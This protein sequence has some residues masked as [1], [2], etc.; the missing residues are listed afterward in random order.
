M[1]EGAIDVP[2]PGA[3]IPAGVLTVEGW[4]AYGRKPV[5][6]VFVQAGDQGVLRASEQVRIDVAEHFASPAMTECGFRAEFDLRHLM[7]QPDER[8]SI[9]VAVIVDKDDIGDLP[10]PVVK[11]LGSV[12]VVVDGSL[13]SPETAISQEPLPNAAA[14]LNEALAHAELGLPVPKGARFRGLKR[15]VARLN[16]PFLHRQLAFNNAVVAELTLQLSRALEDRV[17]VYSQLENMASAFERIVGDLR[18]ELDQ[19]LI[20]HRHQLDLVQRQAFQRHYE[21]L[22]GLRSELTEMAL[23]LEGVRKQ[24]DRGDSLVSRRDG[25]FSESAESLNSTYAAFE[26]T[27]RGSFD[28][29]KD[30][31]RD[32]LG[33]VL[34]LDRHG[35]VLDVGCGR[36]EWLEVLKEA[37]VEAYGVD[38]DVEFVTRCVDRGLDA[39]LDDAFRHLSDIPEESLAAVTAFHVAEHL[40]TEMIEE[41]IDLSA[42]SLCPGGLLILETPNPENLVVGSSTFYIDPSHIRPLNPKFL[43]F[44]VETKGFVDV[45]V[46]FKHPDPALRLPDNDAPWAADLLPLLQAVNQRLFGERDFA[47]VAR[48]G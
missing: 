8:V 13:A 20:V 19:Q 3:R 46:R 31:A 14:F 32:Y 4:A 28:L 15:L 39:R 25:N 38:L 37:G 33:D 30:R 48:R 29:I 43:A 12:D 2:T 6:E 9:D 34:A 1:M 7:G 10:G 18:T 36:G 11:T 23:E 5:L 44:L 47:I 26:D 17:R 41:L 45:D 42:R 16:W 21:D 27:F 22:G 35:A 24:V 40:P